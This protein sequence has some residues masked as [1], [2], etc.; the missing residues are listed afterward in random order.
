[1]SSAASVRRLREVAGDDRGVSVSCHFRGGNHRRAGRIVSLSAKLLVIVL[2]MLVNRS[3]RV[4]APP[5]LPVAVLPLMVVLMSVKKPGPELLMAR[6]VMVC[7]CGQRG[8][9]DRQRTGRQDTAT[10]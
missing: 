10:A 9:D 2:L 4:N 7:Y 3:A 1:M 8:V 6:A 5:P